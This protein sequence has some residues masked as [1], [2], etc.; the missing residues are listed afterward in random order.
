VIAQPGGSNLGLGRHWHFFGAMFWVLNG[1]V[2]VALLF[3]TNQWQRLVPTSWSIF[4]KA[5]ETALAYLHFHLPAPSLYAGIYDPL[6]KLSYFAVVFLLGPF[7]IATAAAQSPAVEGY[8]PWYAKIFGGRQG[9]RLLHFLGLLAFI[10]FIIVHTFMVFVT[11]PQKNFGDIIFGQHQTQGGAA[12]AIGLSLIILIFATYALTS[13]VSLRHPRAIQRGLSAFIRPWMKV[14][15]RKT[16]SRQHYKP[17]EISSYFLINGSPPHSQEYL[18]MLWTGFRDYRLKVN[19]LVENPL[20]LS[21]DDIKAMPKQTQITKHNC[22]QGWT[23][24]GEW[25]GVPLRHILDLARPAPNAK[26]IVFHSYSRDTEG[27]PYYE[28]IGIDIAH[29]PQTILAYEM[30]GQLLPMD[31]GAPLRLRAEVLLGFKMVKWIESIEFV[32]TYSTI[33]GGTGGSRE[34]NKFYEQAVPI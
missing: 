22:I 21:L 26:Y 23:S 27:H 34:D 16:I 2:Y 18:A 25:G 15:A 11:G 14:L 4:P 19:G 5:W 13:W 28:S 24:I 12:L 1:V 9:A 30:N 7:M 3:I 8:F 6:Q 31:H 32:E 33:R 17:S 29:H 10:G 20:S